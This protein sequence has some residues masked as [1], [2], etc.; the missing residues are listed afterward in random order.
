MDYMDLTVYCPIKAVKLNH[1]ALNNVD[2]YEKC[3]W[4]LLLLSSKLLF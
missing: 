3:F 4:K 2:E 1:S